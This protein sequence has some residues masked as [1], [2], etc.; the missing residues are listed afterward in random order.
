MFT[1]RTLFWWGHYLG[2]SLILKGD[3]LPQHMDK[4]VANKDNP[5]WSDVYLATAPTPWEWSWTDENFKKIL[6]TSNAELQNLIET[7]RIY[8][9]HPNFSNERSGI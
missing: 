7:H 3:D 1:Y 2:F 9:N 4:L 5:A 6:T 8:K